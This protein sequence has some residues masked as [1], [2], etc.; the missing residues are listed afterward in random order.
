MRNINE[1]IGTIK[2]INFDGVINDRE[3]VRLQTWVDSNRNIAYEFRPVDLIKI[4]D[5]ILVDHIID[6]DARERLIKS[7]ESFL[8]EIGDNF[9]RIYELDGIIEGIICDGEVNEAEIYNLK[10][11]IPYYEHVIDNSTQG[12]GRAWL[13]TW[14]PDNWDWEDYKEQCVATKQGGTCVIPW[15]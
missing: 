15:T 13:L 7:A 10:D 11:W 12:S 5:E 14:N 9:N 8:D 6:D 4:V 2:G 3:V 1:L